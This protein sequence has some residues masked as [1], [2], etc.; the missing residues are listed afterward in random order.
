MQTGTLEE[1]KAAVSILIA[2]TANMI[3][4]LSMVAVV[5][6][7]PMLRATLVCFLFL[8]VPALLV[9]V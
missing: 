7:R 1:W 5:G 2:F 3:F 6:T 9:F 8:V 4:K